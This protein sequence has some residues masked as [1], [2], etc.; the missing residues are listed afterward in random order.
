LP[1][2]FE[3]MHKLPKSIWPTISRRSDTVE[4]DITHRILMKE[5]MEIEVSGHNHGDDHQHRHEV[6]T[7]CGFGIS[8]SRHGQRRSHKRSARTA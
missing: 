4:R 7:L 3:T 1:E 6:V 5:F 2:T 8:A